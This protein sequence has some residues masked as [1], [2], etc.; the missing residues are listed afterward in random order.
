VWSKLLRYVG[1]WRLLGFGYWV[2]VERASGRFVGEVGLADFRRELSPPLGDGPEAGWVL[3]SW[4]HGAG[5][6]TEAVQAAIAWGE[7]RFGA[8]AR[9]TSVIDPENLASIRV[10]LKC[11]FKE[12]RR[13][14]YK[15][16]AAVVFERGM[17]A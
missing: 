8:G 5:F 3:A 4:A 7:G 2:V 16:S 12:L 15:G 10:A 11:G 14:T 13:T 6:A 1:H 17:S 9:M